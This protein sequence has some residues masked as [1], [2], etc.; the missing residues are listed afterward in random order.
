MLTVVVE[1]GVRI[2]LPAPG[3]LLGFPKKMSRPPWLVLPPARDVILSHFRDPTE[4]SSF[5]LHTRRAPPLQPSLPQTLSPSSFLFFFL[6]T[7]P[8]LAVS[9]R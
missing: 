8:H 1:T 9:F 7:A 5:L 4:A 6:S 3:P 2:R